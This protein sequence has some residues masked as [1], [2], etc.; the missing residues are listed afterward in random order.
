MVNIFPTDESMNG[1]SGVFVVEQEVFQPLGLTHTRYRFDAGP[2]PAM[3]YTRQ[4]PNPNVRAVSGWYPAWDE[5]KPGHDFLVAT[6]MGGGY[7]TADDLARFMDAFANGRVVTRSL[8]A[9]M[10]TGYID[11]DYGG[12]DGYGFET[13]TLNGVR[14][15][16]H[17]GALASPAGSFQASSGY[18]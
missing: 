3:G 8:A 17:C 9:Q 7:S 5:P 2:T 11:A 6:P 14:I 1:V 4:R 16:G 15:V 13:R 10:L 18:R 12:R